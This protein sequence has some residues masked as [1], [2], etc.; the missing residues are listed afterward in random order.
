M[1]L[2]VSCNMSRAL[3]EKSLI[4]QFGH[5]RSRKMFENLVSPQ[6]DAML[7]LADPKCSMMTTPESE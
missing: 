3:H 5:K 2:Q 6:C 7:G 4:Y 1:L